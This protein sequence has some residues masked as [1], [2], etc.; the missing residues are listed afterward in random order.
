MPRIRTVKP[1]FYRH[2][3]LQDLERAHPGAYAMLVFSGLWT[4]AD[5]AG[6]FEWRPRQL[7]LDILPFLDF[8][9]TATLRLLAEAGFVTYYRVGGKEYGA[10]PS[11]HAHQRLSGKEAQEKSKIPAPEQ[12]DGSDSEPPE[13]QRGSTGEASGKQLPAQEEEGSSGR[14]KGRES[15][16]ASD[17]DAA[18]E[19]PLRE[20]NDYPLDF[21]LTW[22]AY[23]KRAGG[24][25]KRD[26]Y[27]AWC[28]RRKHGVDSDTLRE[29]VLRYSA[30]LHAT[31][32]IGTEYVK[33]AATFFGPG[34]HYA[35][36]W[37]CP[38]EKTP[39][40][41]DLAVAGRVFDLC[42]THGFTAPHS[43]DQHRKR[44]EALAADGTIT[45]VEQ[46]MDAVARVKP[47]EVLRGIRPQD[48]D[49]A[50]A[51]IARRLAA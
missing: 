33:T 16:A 31:G 7:K 38:A 50:V 20:R 4:A 42:V 12:H 13:Q 27:K 15:L 28:A 10:I 5:C 8:D 48:R 19:E 40:K 30:Y 32:K 46:F 6:R 37:E 44:A 23:P 14:G 26:A 43:L 21:E 22:N 24:N 41:S 18:G 51:E 34:L 36:A 11:F 25:S 17:S 45:N 39:A 49:K 3:G 1:S 2:E 9:M 47:W 29:G 35:E